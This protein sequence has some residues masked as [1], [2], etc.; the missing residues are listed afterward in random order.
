MVLGH[1]KQRHFLKK[2]VGR[3]EISHAYLFSGPAKLGKKQVG[4]EFLS[5]LA[6]QSP[7]FSK[8]PCQSCPS[9]QAFENKLHPDFFWIEEEK[10]IPISK[11][12]ELIF[13][14]SLK[15][16]L[17]GWKMGLLDK[18]HLMTPE[19]QNCLLKTLEEPQGATCLVL[20]TER[21]FLL[22]PTILSRVQEIKFFAVPEER[23]FKLLLK[24]TG[25]LPERAKQI[26]RLSF[27]RPLLAQEFALRPEKFGEQ[28]QRAKD[29]LDLLTGDLVFRFQY[30]K[31]LASSPDLEETFEL[32]LNYLRQV[33][34]AKLKTNRFKEF[35]LVGL[36]RALEAIEETRFLLL[37]YNVNVRLALENLF[38]RL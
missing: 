25:L 30:A 20:V 31:S 35:S 36:R 29:I 15:P 4:L 6:C 5:W 1:Q 34:M 7:E 17:A 24:E 2:S 10:A 28:K 19:A 22:L 16:S 21:P 14:L 13:K 26:A 18:A 8:R 32:W 23:I 38:L 33:L 3:G 11:I 12:R 37:N 27:G 9:C